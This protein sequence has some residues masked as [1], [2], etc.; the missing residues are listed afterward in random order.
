MVSEL[1][2]LNEMQSGHQRYGGGVAVGLVVFVAIVTVGVVVASRDPGSGSSQLDVIAGVPLLRGAYRTEGELADG[3]RIPEGAVL[4]GD[5]WPS[6]R[7][8]VS[9]VESD[10][11]GW[12]ATFL[13][14]G[15]LQYVADDVGA[16]AEHLGLRP[17]VQ[18][19]GVLVDCYLEDMVGCD[20]VWHDASRLLKMTIERGMVQ[21]PSGR[22]PTSSL[23]LSYATLPDGVELEPSSS[24]SDEQASWPD[25]PTPDGW[26]EPPGPGDG[27]GDGLIPEPADNPE[28]YPISLLVP[29]GAHAVVAPAPGSGAAG[30]YTAL[31]H[32]SGDLDAVWS[33]L[34]EQVRAEVGAQNIDEG[35]WTFEGAEG[36]STSGWVAG[37]DYYDLYSIT[38]NGRS[39]IS[40]AT[41]YD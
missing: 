10:G 17:L 1:F 34:T 22:R 24:T 18:E 26:P 40:I 32:V 27:L 39:W 31:L 41:S 36:R 21:T 19:D 23:E 14:V 3:L 37:G 6:D 33:D 35:R 7:I 12:S 13:L 9:E 25:E 38:T 5:L 28:A 4:L 2:K 16:Q 15:D 20:Q 29:E 11:R 8:H 30:T